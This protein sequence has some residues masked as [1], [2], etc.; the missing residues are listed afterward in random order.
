MKKRLMTNEE[1][2]GEKRESAP[3]RPLT[4]EELDMLLGHVKEHLK[5]DPKHLEYEPKNR[6]EEILGRNA[7]VCNTPCALWS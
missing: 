5:D 7:K 6:S 4:P 3:Q 1:K 2:H